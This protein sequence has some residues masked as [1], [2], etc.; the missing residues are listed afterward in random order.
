[1]RTLTI[2]LLALAAVLPGAEISVTGSR[3]VLRSGALE[4]RI[5]IGPAGVRTTSIMMAGWEMLAAPA[6]EFSVAIARE[7]SNR[8]PP[9]LRPEDS[10]EKLDFTVTLRSTWRAEGFDAARYNDPRPN[11]PKWVGTVSLEA[12]TWGQPEAVVTR[13]KPGVTRLT[14]RTRLAKPPALEGVSI[15]LYYEVYEGHPAIRKWAEIRN[16]GSTWL[17]LER[18]VIDDLQLAALTRKPLAAA[19]FGVQ[20]SVVAFEIP[21][22]RAG[23]IAASEI[24]SA[25]RT[26]SEQGAMG[27]S[28]ALFEW[29]LGPGEDFTSEPVFYYGYSGEARVTA[30]SVSTP[31]DRVLEG[32]YMRFLEQRIGIAAKD[33][34]M[35]G[36]Q[37]LT[38]AFFYDNI[39][40]ALVRRLADLAAQ[41]GFSELL[42]DMGWQKGSLGT[43][44]DPAK[45]P[46]FAATSEYVRSKGLHL[47]AW[48]SSYRD[49]DSRDLAAMPNAPILP[50]LV[51]ST[52]YPGLAMSFASPW[53][54]YYVKDVVEMARRYKLTYVK[55]DFSN[56]LYGDLAEGHESRTRKE[57]VLRGL[58]GLLQAQAMLRRT[59]PELVNEI[60]HEI[61]WGTP[62]VPAD[63]AA[64]KQ[65]A[66]FHI[67]P[68]EALGTDLANQFKGRSITAEE[69]AAVLRQGCWLARQRFYSHRGMPLYALEFYAAGTASHQGSLTAAIQDRQV[70]SWLMGAPVCYSGDLR[71]LS[72]E[73]VA[74][75]AKR[76]KEV[77]RLEAT[78]GIY[79][80][81]QFSGVPEP[82]DVDWH[83]WGKLDEQGHGAVVVVRGSGGAARRAVNIPWVRRDRTYRALGL[84]SGKMYGVLSGA[85][86]Q[87]AGVTLELPPYGQDLLEIAGVERSGTL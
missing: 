31:L 6:R 50:N 71:T 59:A 29:V 62:G 51:R 30:S 25:L 38:W 73:N 61:Y 55:Q 86:L 46:D 83:W 22:S 57:G 47:G 39:N 35:H 18:M 12:S 24:P 74:H 20:P 2:A 16:G 78:Y 15:D 81:F 19:M 87:D 17:K 26:I 36:P 79:Q 56:M 43:D 34:P 77:K 65:T 11:A 53:R 1:M 40:D 67:P 42:L 33:A 82:T 45:F 84:F 4:R 14:V 64:L 49:L 70:A 9:A 48:V 85:A 54:H 76:F 7:E 69:H 8:K 37:W 66:R 10:W 5:E 58:R 52:K 44:P 80:R 3:A 32:P 41:A 13:P 68:N 21:G 28:P 75:Y 72:P 63:L 23:L 27:Y 60:T